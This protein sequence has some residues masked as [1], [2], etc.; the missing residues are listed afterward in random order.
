MIV[1]K[2]LFLGNHNSSVICSL[3]DGV[4]VSVL[5]S[6]KEREKDWLTRNQDN[7]SEWSYK[8]QGIS[9]RLQS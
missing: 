9:E 8:Y 7:V 3:I 4:M 2:V 6:I 5:V 1:C